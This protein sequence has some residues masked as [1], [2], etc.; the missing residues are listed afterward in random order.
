M[1]VE[2]EVGTIHETIIFNMHITLMATN[3]KN[4]FDMETDQSITST[5]L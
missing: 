5:L 3:I 2:S 1:C 4:V